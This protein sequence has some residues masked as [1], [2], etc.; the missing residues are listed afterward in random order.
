MIAKS[1]PNDGGRF[2]RDRL[3]ELLGN[4][5]AS[6][7][8]GQAFENENGGA[9]KVIVVVLVAA[10][11]N[12]APSDEQMLA[13]L[14]RHYGRAGCGG[15]PAAPFESMQLSSEVLALLVRAL[16]AKSAPGDERRVPS[17]EPCANLP[18]LTPRERQV[19]QFVL[20]GFQNKRIANELR[21]SMRTVEN[22]RASIMR[23]TGSKSLPALVKFAI[24]AGAAGGAPAPGRLREHDDDAATDPRCFPNLFAAELEQ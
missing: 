3:A 15:G 20:D 5:A 7:D 23:K 10:K 6:D 21:I 2:Q 8:R 14:Q 13:Q 12:P 1:R 18:A 19:L 11:A 4:V 24:A 9:P 22:H 17:A 16:E